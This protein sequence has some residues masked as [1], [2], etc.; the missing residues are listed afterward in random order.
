MPYNTR[1]AGLMPA[2]VA[3]K[4]FAHPLRT[5]ILRRLAGETHS[6]N[7]LAQIF[8]APLGNVSYHVKALLELGLIR[9]VDTAT[10]RGAIEHY[11]SLNPQTADA[12]LKDLERIV[13]ELRQ[14]LAEPA[15]E[16]L[17]AAA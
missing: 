13:A 6:P 15:D 11:Y 14:V 5:F 9:L 4:A 12:V 2:N 7:E 1:T 8:D 16:D 10:R 3:A 17:E